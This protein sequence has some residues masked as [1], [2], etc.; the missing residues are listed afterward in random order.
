MTTLAIRGRLILAA[1]VAVLFA[2]ITA[3]LP[4]NE[5]ARA[6]QSSD[7][8]GKWCFAWIPEKQ[9]EKP[10]ERGALL[11]G[12][13]WNSGDT[14][15][16]SFLDGDRGVQDKV[17]AFAK[18]WTRAGGG[19]ANLTFNF[20]NDTNSDIRISFKYTGSWSVIG[21]TCRQ[22]T[23]KEQPTMNFGWL[24]SDTPDSEVKRVVLHEFGH[25]IGLAHE[26]QNPAGGIE[27]DQVQV[28]KDLSGPPNNWS[29]PVISRNM[30]ETYSNEETNHTGTTDGSS[31]MMYPIPKTWTKNGFSAGLNT[32]LSDTD[33]SFVREQYP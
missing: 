13:K 25:A 4:T 15:S 33:K 1:A 30:F 8:K 31:I 19:P 26:H 7:Y 5:L 22:I 3:G 28:I 27:W 12:A 11:R 16:V 17:S 20:Q 6:D 21:T 2:I 23:N 14:I 24:T 29:I 32:A 10:A 18:H 9:K